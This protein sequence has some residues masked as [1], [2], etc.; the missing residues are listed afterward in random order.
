MMFMRRAV[1]VIEA[2]CIKIIHV[3]NI[4]YKQ[5]SGSAQIQCRKH[6]II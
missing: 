5:E 2:K 3:K 6:T 4:I 1:N